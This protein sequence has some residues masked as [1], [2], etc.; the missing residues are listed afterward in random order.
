MPTTIPTPTGHDD[1]SDAVIAR[2]LAA[3][4]ASAQDA[5]DY[6]DLHGTG[7]LEAIL[8]TPR[9]TAAQ[10]E[11][12]TVEAAASDTSDTSGTSIPIDRAD[13]TN[14]TVTPLRH[15]ALQR[16]RLRRAL[17]S[18]AAVAAI[19]L[20]GAYVIQNGFPAP[21]GQ[22]T[23]TGQSG[24]SGQVLAI[25]DDTRAAA[26]APAG[27]VLIQ[28]ASAALR[29]PVTPVSAT[30]SYVEQTSAARVGD[31]SALTSSTTQS[32]KAPDGSGRMVTSS[33]S[34]ADPLAEADDSWGPGQSPDGG[35]WAAGRLRGLVLADLSS[36]PAQLSVQVR[37]WASQQPPMVGERPGTVAN[38]ELD[39][40]AVLLA[41]P[42]AGPEL[43]AAAFTV[44]SERSDVGLLGEHTDPLGRTGTAVEYDQVNGATWRVTLTFDPATST[45]LSSESTLVDRGGM[46]W[47]ATAPLGAWSWTAYTTTAMVDAVGDTSPAAG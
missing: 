46:E 17:I 40:L 16:R 26:V 31:L 34:T 37:D 12:S 18:A 13:S 33:G 43:R 32:W 19:A 10:R 8:A 47:L 29:E 39:L 45:L 38:A 24:Q 23:T 30:V 28:L 44:L 35:A 5:R 20:P 1:G 3:R 2:L 21:F 22:Q 41:E 27:T 14:S 11:A 4:P 25:T 9:S 7:I 15:P 42:S 6:L 36:D